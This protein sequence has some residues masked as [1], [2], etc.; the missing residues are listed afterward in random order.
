[1]FNLTLWKYKAA[2]QKGKYSKENAE[3]YQKL[4]VTIERISI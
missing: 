3:T 2:I 1:M 4:G